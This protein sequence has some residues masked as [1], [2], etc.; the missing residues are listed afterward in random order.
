MPDPERLAVSRCGW[1][2]L[3]Y[4]L[5]S[6]QP[7]PDPRSAGADLVELGVAQEPAGREVVDVAV[8]A[9]QLDRVERHLCGALG[10]VE[11]A[12]GGILAGRFLAVAGGGHGIDIGSA[13]A[14]RGVHV[15][16][17]AL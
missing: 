10:G 12:A 16:E 3:R 2:P 8:A 14:E 6:D 9:E 15:G 4:D 5:P 11:D 7:A 1:L 13:G 17:L